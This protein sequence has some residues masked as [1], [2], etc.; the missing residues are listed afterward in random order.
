VGSPS[1][2]SPYRCCL[3]LLL[4]GSCNHSRLA[5]PSV[6]SPTNSPLADDVVARV[7]VVKVEVPVSFNVPYAG[8]AKRAFAGGLPLS[9]GS[10]LRL[11]PRAGSRCLSE[12]DANHGYSLLALSDRGPNTNAPSFVDGAGVSRGSKAF[13]AIDFA[14]QL[15]TIDV[16]SQR[17]ARVGS[18]V[19]LRS[20]DAREVGL[21]PVSLTTELALSE[22]LSVLPASSAGID[23][24]GLDFDADGNIWLCEEYGP[25][26]LRVLPK[27]GQ[28][29]A[30]LTPGSGLPGVLAN[31]QVN[32]GCEGVAVTPSGK[33]YGI[34]QST[35]DVAHQTKGIAQFIRVFEY[36]PATQKT[37]LFGYPHDVSA[38]KTSADGKMGDLIAL[39][40]TR[41]L[42]IEEGKDTNGKLRNIVYEFDLGGASDLSEVLLTSGPNTGKDL[43]F[44]TSAELARQVRLAAKT[45]VLDL[46]AYGFTAEKAEGL[47][48]LDERTLVVINDNDFGAASVIEGDKSGGTD[49]ASYGVNARGALTFM[50]APSAGVYKIHSLPNEVQ[51]TSLFIVQLRRA[52]AGYCAS[53]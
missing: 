21:P 37:R 25:S 3:L 35:M 6:L 8:A 12:R 2:L 9:L 28:I 44:A 46:R 53:R 19:P 32:R 38:Y 45:R 11:K 13:L 17:G 4:V 5:P 29:V 16:N 52:F 31:R 14:P 15:V 30:R 47:A 34:L 48:L 49:P 41:F 50:G 7:E 26:L 43:E 18:V 22:S 24:E 27:T 10:G 42:T 36:D 40:D 23:P 20:G 1:S 39:D 33:V 51:E